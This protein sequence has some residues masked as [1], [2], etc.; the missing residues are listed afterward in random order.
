M[1]NNN[2]REKMWQNVNNLGERYT[3][4]IK[5]PLELLCVFKLFFVK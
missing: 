4:F 1:D 3:E 5:L 2:M